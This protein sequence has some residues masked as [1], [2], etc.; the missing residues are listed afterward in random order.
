MSLPVAVPDIFV[1]GKAPSSSVDR[2][3][4][5]S[6]LDP[7]Q[8]ALASLPNSTTSAYS[9]IFTRR[10]IRGG[11][12][13]LIHIYKNRESC[14]Y[15]ISNLCFR[16]VGNSLKAVLCLMSADGKTGENLGT[17]AAGSQIC[18]GI[19]HTA[20]LIGAKGRDALAV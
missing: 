13:R 3:H 5:L 11:A 1:G 12:F 4:A 15:L 8:A 9:S 19:S 20:A 2:C 6:S 14:S 17:L 16:P 18:F 7:P 10:G